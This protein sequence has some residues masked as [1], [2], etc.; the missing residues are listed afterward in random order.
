MWNEHG[1]ILCMHVAGVE[2]VVGEDGNWISE[3]RKVFNPVT[4]NAEQSLL[5]PRVFIHVIFIF[6][7]T[8]VSYDLYSLSVHIQ[9]NWTF[10]ISAVWSCRSVYCFQQ[11]GV[12]GNRLPVKF[13][14][15]SKLDFQHLINNSCESGIR[16]AH[17]ISSEFLNWHC[18]SWAIGQG[19]FTFKLVTTKKILVGN[20]VFVRIGSLKL[21][22]SE[23]VD[24][25]L[26]YQWLMH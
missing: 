4:Y 19:C 11:F 9:S 17:P 25:G 13:C 21:T 18:H 20:H 26:G 3:H 23:K 8:W 7:L 15:Q 16:H 14:F 1:N 24:S 6:C 2:V 5:I 12:E 22:V 10:W